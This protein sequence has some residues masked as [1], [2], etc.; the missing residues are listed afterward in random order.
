MAELRSHVH[1]FT[2]IKVSSGLSGAPGSS[3]QTALVPRVSEHV[4]DS[5]FHLDAVMRKAESGPLVQDELDSKVLWVSAHLAPPA[6]M[7]C[8]MNPF[9]YENDLLFRIVVLVSFFVNSTQLRVTWE[10]ETSTE[11][12]PRSD[13][14]V[15]MSVGHSLDYSLI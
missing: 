5:H 10:E 1:L 15:N 2:I 8:W 12:L 9:L 4:L 6:V 7:L 3:P 14:P 11:E 13:W